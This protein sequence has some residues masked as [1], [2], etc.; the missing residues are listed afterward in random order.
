[1]RVVE[2]GLRS[3]YTAITNAGNGVEN[4]LRYDQSDGDRIG[5]R[6]GGIG[7]RLVFRPCDREPS[8]TCLMVRDSAHEVIHRH[9][10]LCVHLQPM[11]VCERLNVSRRVVQGFCGLRVTP[12]T[13]LQQARDALEVV[14]GT[15]M[16]LANALLN[17]VVWR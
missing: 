4:E 16:Q 1:M 11:H 15:V 9:T 14:L 13:G 7:R 3:Q 10:N 6:D 17:R 12:G 2:A 8:E 5:R